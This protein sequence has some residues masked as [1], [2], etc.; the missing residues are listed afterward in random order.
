MKHFTIWRK[1]RLHHFL[2]LY[3][4]RR[5]YPKSVSGG[6]VSFEQKTQGKKDT[7]KKRHLYCLQ[8]QYTREH[9]T[10]DSAGFTEFCGK[11]L[12]PSGICRLL[13]CNLRREWSAAVTD[14]R[15]NYAY[16]LKTWGWLKASREYFLAYCFI[17]LRSSF[18][19]SFRILMAFY[20]A[21]SLM[22]K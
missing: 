6:G 1:L 22:L 8:M 12:G 15:L 9:P 4:A 18:Y 20:S 11:R 14:C 2:Q 7:R 17:N 16:W 19:L 3:L 21:K 10:V 5:W 13:F